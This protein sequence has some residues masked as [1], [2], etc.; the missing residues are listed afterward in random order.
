MIFSLL[1]PFITNVTNQYII[2]HCTFFAPSA[3]IA[4]LC[5]IQPPTH[6]TT[7][8]TI[9]AIT[10]TATPHTELQTCTLTDPIGALGNASTH[11]T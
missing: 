11:S 3:V 1:N 7:P 5:C 9:S 4:R 6:T 2:S 8:E 10:L